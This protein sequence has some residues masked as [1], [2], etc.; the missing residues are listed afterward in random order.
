VL[1]NLVFC[2]NL[3]FI[4]MTY[5]ICYDITDNKLRL[6]ISKRLEKAGCVRLQK[7]VFLAP[8]FDAK[9]LQILRGG[10]N[11][12]MRYV[13]ALTPEESLLVIPIEKDNTVDIV[14]VGNAQPLM[15]TLKKYLYK[16][17]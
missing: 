12:I 14:W 6:K 8:N 13:V 2:L 7:S 17:F 11:S 9:R 4:P 3:A 10:I 15:D 16:L 1:F 5:L